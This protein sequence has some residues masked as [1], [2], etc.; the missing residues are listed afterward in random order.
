[1]RVLC[2]CLSRKWHVDRHLVA[3][4]VGVEGGTSEGVELDGFSLDHLGLECLDGETVERRGT[5]EEYGVALHDELE[6]VPNDGFATI[7]D[8]LGALDGLH[9]AAL[10]E[11]ADD[12]GLVESA[13]MSLGRPH[14]P[15]L[16]SGPTTITERP[17]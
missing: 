9:N 15:I 5:V 2:L 16:S 17:E 14:S 10:D 1:M 6:D 4:E 11:L 8:L 13:A 7:D 3:V 12:E